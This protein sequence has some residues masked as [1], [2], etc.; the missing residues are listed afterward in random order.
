MGNFFYPMTFERLDQVGY[1]LGYQKLCR[2][3]TPS[4]HEL[5]TPGFWI[6]S[7]FLDVI[8]EYPFNKEHLIIH[9]SKLEWGYLIHVP[10]PLVRFSSSATQR[11]DESTFI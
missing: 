8:H 11:G 1:G 9:Y 5:I 4:S 3:I 10:H 7:L 6:P 2:S